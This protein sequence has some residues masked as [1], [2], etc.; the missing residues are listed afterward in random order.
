MRCRDLGIANLTCAWWNRVQTFLSQDLQEKLEAA[1]EQN[2]LLQA[3]LEA[4]ETRSDP[5]TL[6]ASRS[7]I[8]PR[9]F[10]VFVLCL[11][12]KRRFNDCKMSYETCGQKH[13]LH[14]SILGLC[15]HRERPQ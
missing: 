10:D 1:L 11:V 2:V 12:I 8:W 4:A 9:M 7:L 5:S 14:Q 3:D 13:L 6:F 15:P